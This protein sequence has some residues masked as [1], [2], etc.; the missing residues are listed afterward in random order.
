MTIKRSRKDAKGARTQ[1]KLG[2]PLVPLVYSVLCV[3]APFASLRDCLHVSASDLAEIK[4]ARG[5]DVR[6][7]RQIA[8]ALL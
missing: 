2:C 3:F 5:P 1:R 6:G 4:K 7:K 8:V